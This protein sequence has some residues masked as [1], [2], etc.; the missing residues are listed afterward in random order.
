MCCWKGL[1]CD[2]GTPPLLG[3]YHTIIRQCKTCLGLAH[4]GDDEGLGPRRLAVEH[5]PRRGPLDHQ[6]FVWLMCWWLG[7]VCIARYVSG[8]GICQWGEGVGKRPYTYTYMCVGKQA[9]HDPSSLLLPAPCR[10]RPRCPPSR[11]PP[12]T[13]AP[14]RG[15]LLWPLLLNVRFGCAE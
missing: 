5:V 13:P 1:H 10:G 8:W 3:K 9:S 2:M 7:C 6:L 15:G 14:A 12:Q 11:P 4:H